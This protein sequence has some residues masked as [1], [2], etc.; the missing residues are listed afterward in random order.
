MK[1][2]TIRIP[3]HVNQ[4]TPT[5][6]AE[7]K[8]SIV[9][10]A[11]MEKRKRSSFPRTRSSDVGVSLKK[12]LQQQGE[13]RGRQSFDPLSKRVRWP[14]IISQ[15][16]YTGRFM[17]PLGPPG[18][19][20]VRRLLSRLNRPAA[21]AARLL[22]GQVLVR[23]QGRRRMACRIVETEAYL[24]EKDPAA[25]AFRGRT[26]RTAP[27]WG[28]PGTLY[29]YFIYGM[30]HCL[31]IVVDRDRVPGCVLI[32]AA[33]PLEGSGLGPES[34]RGPGR[35]CRTLGISVDDS[36]RSLFEPGSR[37]YLR[38]GEAP[39][40]AGVSGRVGVRL[41]P[42]WPLRFFDPESGAVS[43]GPRTARQRSLGPPSRGT[44][45]SRSVSCRVRSRGE[46]PAK[47]RGSR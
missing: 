36:E 32:R 25:H 5:L 24:G 39:F 16:A 35:L 41:A 13:A 46:K 4:V 45:G 8:L 12:S 29:V 9:R 42:D 23:V 6:A 1:K 47:A 44:G 28:P 26:P 30:Y 14:G 33:E 7:D 31:N 43:K 40:E 38:E 34:C 2:K 3:H 18:K 19:A 10:I 11:E 37:L 17:E 22:L 21:E 15:A 27:L 20:E